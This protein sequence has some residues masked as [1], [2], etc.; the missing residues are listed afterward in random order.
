[1]QPETRLVSNCIGLLEQAFD[2]LKKIDDEVFVGLSP[3]SPRGSVGGHLRHVLDFYQSFIAGIEAG[4]INYNLRKRG[5]PAE[6]DRAHAAAVIAE[7]IAALRSLP[8]LDG[9]HALL[10]SAEESAGADPIWCTSTI[11]RELDFLQSHTVHHYS[12]IAM[13]LRLHEIEPGAEFGVAS[14]TLN[15]W[16]E[17]AACAR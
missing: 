15:Y 8:V 2:L 7:T 5:L 13:F 6:R 4:R 10:V 1:M 9:S 3:L 16:K 17:E 11:L 14:S 12:L